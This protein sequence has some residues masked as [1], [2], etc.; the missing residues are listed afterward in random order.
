ML[1]KVVSLYLV[2]E[3]KRDVVV[4]YLIEVVRVS[5]FVGSLAWPTTEQ[6]EHGGDQGEN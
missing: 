5:M 2:I 1:E 3:G 4:L 6:M